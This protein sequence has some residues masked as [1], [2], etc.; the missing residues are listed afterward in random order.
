[1]INKLGKQI[2]ANARKK[3]FNHDDVPRLIALI[4]SEASEALEHDR[5]DRYFG[6]KDKKFKKDFKNELEF[7]NWYEANGKE[8]LE[9]EL[10]DIM[11]RAMDLAASKGIDMEYHIKAKMKYNALRPYKHGGKK[12]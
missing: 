6:T 1:M 12:Y 11:I 4:H 10:A 5:N 9:A 7:F 2:F 3:G 8:T